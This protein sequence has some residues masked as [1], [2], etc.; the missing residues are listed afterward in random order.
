[1][2]EKKIFCLFNT[3][4]TQNKLHAANSYGGGNILAAEQAGKYMLK[5]ITEIE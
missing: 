4:I 3:N 2:E 5:C 1:M